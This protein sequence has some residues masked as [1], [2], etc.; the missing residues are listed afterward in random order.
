MFLIIPGLRAQQ[1]KEKVLV[2]DVERNFVV[3]LPKG[4]NAQQH[5]PVMILLHG[6]N[7]DADDILAKYTKYV[8]KL[9]PKGIETKIKVHS[10]GPAC[11]VGTDNRFIK[12]AP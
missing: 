6:A 12:V 9:T 4:Y 10:K 11:V 2:D 5:Y 1:T 8:K 3:R 7:Q